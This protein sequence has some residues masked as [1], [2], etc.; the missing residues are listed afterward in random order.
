MVQFP[1]SEISSDDDQLLPEN[2]I[3]PS[4]PFAQNQCFLF[5]K[6]CAFF[7]ANTAFCTGSPGGQKK[8]EHEAAF[9]LG[10]IECLS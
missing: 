2:V 8:P 5:R 9:F 1:E 6:K 10:K 7:S 4:K 3:A